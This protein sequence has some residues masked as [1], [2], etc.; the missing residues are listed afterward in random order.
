M[1]RAAAIRE[2]LRRGLDVGGTKKGPADARSSD[3]GVLRMRASGRPTRDAEG[4]SQSG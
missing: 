1:P 3:F 2:I 4:G